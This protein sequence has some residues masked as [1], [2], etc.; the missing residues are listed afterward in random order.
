MLP[1]PFLKKLVYSLP[2]LM[3][4]ILL[5]ALAWI[6]LARGRH[7]AIHRVFAIL[8]LMGGLL[9][10]DIIIGINAPSR[11]IAL[12][13]NRLGHLVHPFLLPVF[14][15]F[16]HAYLGIRN[17]RWLLWI[18]YGFAL[19]IAGFAPGQWLIKDVR[20]YTF[21]YFGQGGPL[22]IFMACGAIFATVYNLTILYQA[23][24]AE[25]RS[26]Q[27]NKLK[28]LFAG[29]GMLGVLSS[30]NILTLYGVP[31]YPPGA[32]GFIPMVVFAAGFFKYDLLDMGLL[33]RKGI[34]YSCLTALMTA[35]YAGVIIAA[36]TIFSEFAL[37]DSYLFPLT[38]FVLITFIFGP[39]KKQ[40]QAVIDR[41]FARNRIDYG[42]TIR[43]V[44]QSI[45]SVLDFQEISRLL[46]ATFIDAMQVQTVVLF[47][48]DGSGKAF[49]TYAMAGKTID[50]APPSAM[51]SDTA[52]VQCL[53]NDK[54][55]IIRKRL[56]GDASTLSH[57]T[58]LSELDR[59]QGE[60]VLPLRFADRLNGVLVLAEKRSG[61]MYSRE[62][63][64]LLETLCHQSAL[65]VENAKA[66]QALSE[67]NQTLEAKVLARTRD[68]QQALEEKE[69]T[70]EQLIRSESL[71]ALGQLV[72][73]VAHELN[74][75][76]TSVTSL[77]QSTVEELKTWE[78]GAP[79]D[80]DLL[81][82]LQFA[83]KE[84]ARAK[85][86]VASLLGLA[87]QTQTYQEAVDLNVVVQDALRVLHNQY[88][89]SDLDMVQDLKDRLPEI[90]GNFANL[91]QVAMNIIKN[92]IQAVADRHGRIQ[93][94]TDV[95]EQKQQILFTCSD[96][97]PGI[98]PALFQDVFKPFF[99]TKPV[100]QGTGLGLYIC[101]EIVRKHGGRIDLARA[102]PHGTVVTVRF[103][104]ASDSSSI[105][106]E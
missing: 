31:V 34:F 48:A 42:K 39:I 51:A 22:Y 52:I 23:I 54:R 32:F 80:E 37:T 46:Q 15:H 30:L 63:L 85:A 2:P 89:H 65:A 41:L 26:I 20:H 64:D 86:I 91:G 3:T 93:I 47:L 104:F 11:Q 5:V 4:A 70:Q 99:T 103:P 21:G 72:A 68:L 69:R 9:Y 18:C 83:D 1:D 100:G 77:L 62:D 56:L 33:I 92:A 101:H 88:K 73:G 106:A 7:M 95:D 87:R 19:L 27:K 74:N 90:Q 67:L 14:I 6:A 36:Q 25:A 44:S 84:L 40:V 75:P 49:V 58:L 81:D 94:T 71:A 82:D 35:L 38:L 8:C 79:V 13:S 59:Y 98:D 105:P 43:Q 28:Y 55:P 57:Q 16:F 45:A 12:L 76:L 66:Y 29:F 24:G 102:D 60:L 96:N 10:I 53:S 61:E 97:G 50:Q 78:A 17:R